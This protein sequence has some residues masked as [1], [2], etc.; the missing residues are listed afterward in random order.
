MLRSFDDVKLIGEA[1]N[2][3]EAIELIGRERPD[4][5]LLDLQM[6]R[7][8]ASAS[9]GCSRRAG[10]RSSPSSRP[11]TSTVRAFELN[12]S[13]TFSAVDRARLREALN[14]AQERLERADLRMEPR[15]A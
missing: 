1:S 10:C 15:R 11:M 5:A 3:A 13:I 12:A 8:T 2:G 14:R 7:S 9:C 4:L 6:P